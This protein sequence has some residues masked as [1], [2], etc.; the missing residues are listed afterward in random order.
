[1]PTVRRYGTPQVQTTPLPGARLTAA[2]T[3][4]SEGAGV[5]EARAQQGQALEGFGLTASR[6]ILAI[7]ETER[8]HADDVAQLA[9]NNQLDSWTNKALYD[10]DN[11]ALT[12]KGK[13]A[14]GLP[15][16]VL[17]DFE[18]TAGQ[19]GS[20]LTSDR[21]RQ[22]F[23]R[24]KARHEE[25]LDATLRRH[26]F[27]EM[28]AYETNELQA[29]VENKRD[30]AI[31]NAS[32]PRRVGQELQGAV[33]AIRTSAPRLGLGPEEVQKQIDATQTATHV[34]VIDA[35]LSA[36]KYGAAKVY[37]E[38]TRDQINGDA[39]SKVQK[40]IQEGT[41]RQQAQQAADKII[42]E[43]GTLTEQRDKVRAID[44]PLVRDEVEQRI[45]H[46][47]AIAEKIQRDTEE[48][49][50]RGAY[51]LVDKTGS[52]S[53][54]KPTVWA[55]LDG[56]Q[57]SALREYADRLARGVAVDTDPATFYTLMRASSD[58]PDDFARTNLLTY[59]DRLSAG[60]F[61][62]LVELQTSIRTGDR[63]KA[64]E[65]Q[66]GF[67]SANDI[68]T[69]SLT[70]YG[71]DTSTKADKATKNAV[72]ELYRLVDTRVQAQAT[73]T[74]KKPTNDDVQVIVDGILSTSRTT[75]GS[76]WGMVPFNGVS[77]FDKKTK[78]LIDLT[79]GDVPASDRAQIEESLRRNGL[80]VSDQ[81]VLDVY[82]THQQGRQK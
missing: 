62:Q 60:D 12:V 80:P 5:A 29:F 68:I 14:M 64:D 15:E 20:G 75:P 67:R 33:D 18:Q 49:T 57:R 4:E 77:F 32:D 48:T 26:V 47:S 23:A 69:N 28:Q 19:I 61:K 36:E 9:W 38:E 42:A 13:N 82:I 37:F 65:Q 51:D 46:E 58:L 34:G 27:Q 56:N 22:Q 24:V 7:Q 21:Q 73:L 55:S 31:R 10:P 76:W 35:L 81:T 50:L 11:G 17:G 16:K 71:I 74:G 52:V 79:P 40:A 54:I 53:A 66:S 63:K 41:T 30:N 59:K 3:P 8:Q 45:E 44:D 25:N 78:G 1:M 70:L 39:A 43:G 72:A 2:E 6:D